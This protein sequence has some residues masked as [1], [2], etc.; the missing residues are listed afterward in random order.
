MVSWGEALGYGK[1]IG[2]S[3]RPALLSQFDHLK[4]HI[5]IKVG[6]KMT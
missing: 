6:H 1:G 4:D 5:I 2:K 3:P